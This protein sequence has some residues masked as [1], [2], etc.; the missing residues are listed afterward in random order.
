MFFDIMAQ[1]WVTG[2][3]IPLLIY[4]I[5]AGIR[6]IS[7]EKAKKVHGSVFQALAG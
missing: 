1:L 3:G 7:R 4:F 6:E 2:Q 5:V